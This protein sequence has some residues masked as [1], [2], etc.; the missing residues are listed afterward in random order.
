KKA[1]K[2]DQQRKEDLE[3]IAKGFEKFYELNQFYPVSQKYAN[4]HYTVV[5]FNKDWEYFAFPPDD[6]MRKF[7]PGWPIDDPDHQPNKPDQVNAY[8]YY[9][10]EDGQKFD[11]YAHLQ[12]P[13]KNAVDY[14]QVD[15]ISTSLGQYNYKVSSKTSNEVQ[16]II[17][18]NSPTATMQFVSNP[19]PESSTS[20][21]QYSPENSMVNL[22]LPAPVTNN[23][24]DEPS[25]ADNS[26]A[27]TEADPYNSQN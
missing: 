4:Q 5:N 18:A 23:H 16:E 26:P 11:L 7:I 13:G 3:M 15:Q 17:E 6:Y 24:I 8:L 19:A 22:P 14:N 2:K 21:P 10:K 1:K 9:P 27:A 12:K 25:S 20:T